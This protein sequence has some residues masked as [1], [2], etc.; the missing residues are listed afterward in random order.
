MSD[1][2]R[3]GLDGRAAVVTGASSGLGRHF[4][5]TLAAAGAPVALLARRMDL[6]EH[7][8]A[9]IEGLGGKAAP[10]A[11][12][13]R[14]SDSVDQAIEAAS[15]ALGPLRVVVNNAGVAATGWLTEMDDAAW[16][17]VLDVNLDGV[18]RVARAAGRHMSAH[19]QGGS[20][21]N[22]ASVLGFV[23]LKTVGAY[24][25]SK[26][27]VIQLTRALAVELA[28]DHVRVNAIAPGYFMTDMNRDFLE[29]PK[30]QAL[31]AR[32]P[33]ARAGA[34]EEL[35]GALLLLASDAG[36]FM[37]GSVVTVDG[38]AHLTMG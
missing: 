35:D 17:R 6:L 9:E 24:A 15:E 11:C 38:G 10:I 2:N 29:S 13:V 19:G 23:V 18:F 27:A 20:I 25:V 5:R 34:L 7:L 36:R 22:V 30:G 1:G 37:T 4:A 31:L 21:I 33:F 3:F 14:D 8:A 26:A 28:R 32:I 12:D 16:R